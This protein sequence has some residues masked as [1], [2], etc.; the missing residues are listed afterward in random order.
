MAGGVEHSGQ[1][2]LF[3]GATDLQATIT[4]SNDRKAI[5]TVPPEYGPDDSTVSPGKTRRET[6]GE[7][8]GRKTA[9][10]K[11]TR[12]LGASHGA[13]TYESIQEHGFDTTKGAPVRLTYDQYT[14][15]PE[16]EVKIGDAH[17]RVAAAADI[18]R[19]T[20]RDVWIPVTNVDP[21]L[22]YRHKQ[23]LKQASSRQKR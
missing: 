21:D 11:E 19:T 4:A 23:Q 18:E 16:P 22:P 15:Q 20:G 1:F 13:G 7:M 14:D 9:E 10:S 2:R 3:Y 12:G 6:M 17:H 8:W 5:L